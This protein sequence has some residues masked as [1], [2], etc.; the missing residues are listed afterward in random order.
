MGNIIVIFIILAIITGAIT[1][2]I[3]EKRNG[4]KCI[5]CPHGK[6][7]GSSCGCEDKK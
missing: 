2:V 4:A 3:I 5:G 6:S 7:G 1:K